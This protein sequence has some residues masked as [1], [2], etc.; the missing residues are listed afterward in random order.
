MTKF[1]LEFH[2]RLIYIGDGYVF[3]V[4]RQGHKIDNLSGFILNKEIC[5][6]TDIVFRR[7]KTLYF[8]PLLYHNIPM[9]I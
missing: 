1:D 4:K 7:V 2:V 3:E 6:I 8:I 5:Q 9:M